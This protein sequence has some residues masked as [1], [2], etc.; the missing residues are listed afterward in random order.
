MA[1]RGRPKKIVLTLEE[2]EDLV[3]EKYLCGEALS[4]EE[5]ALALWMIEGRKTPRPMTKVGIMKVEQRALSHLRE[6]FKKY[7]ITQFDDIYSARNRTPAK[8]FGS[9]EID[10]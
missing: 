1:K 3:I 7:G 8:M 2:Q 9:T 5:T 6:G 10:E 4:L